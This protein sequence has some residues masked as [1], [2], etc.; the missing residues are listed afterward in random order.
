MNTQ[1]SRFQQL[2]TAARLTRLCCNAWR[3]G[4]RLSQLER[5]FEGRKSFGITGDKVA[6]FLKL[7]EDL[8]KKR[9]FR[10]E[11]A[12]EKF[13]RRIARMWMEMEDAEMPYS[14]GSC[15]KKINGDPIMLDGRGVCLSCYSQQ[16]PEV[17]TVFA[18]SATAPAPARIALPS[19][20]AQTATRKS[21]EDFHPGLFPDR[22]TR[23]YWMKRLQEP[24]GYAE[25]LK[26]VEEH[27]V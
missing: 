22:E 3:K 1:P 8:K 17:S 13:D 23:D 10:G 4:A 14:C 9:P 2:E 26:V 11:N 15:N 5:I 24:G 7:V 12:D 21:A 19:A 27:N 25:L 20:P 18:R 16:H 6:Q